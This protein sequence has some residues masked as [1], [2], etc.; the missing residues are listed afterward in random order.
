[1]GALALLVLMGWAPAGWSLGLGDIELDSALNEKLNAEIELLD[2]DGL[3]PSE[4]LVSLASAE[5]FRRIGVERFF[6]LTDLRFEVG[7]GADGGGRIE[8]T[9]TQP[10]TEPYLNFLV[11]VLWPNGRMLR[12]YTLLLDP[13][14]F[15]PAPT[16]SVSTPS[17]SPSEDVAAGQVVGFQRIGGKIEPGLDRH[18]L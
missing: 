13:P 8:V 5:D 12:E 3:Q 9:S 1:M 16:Q 4:I 15:S 2:A 18:D 10:V 6:F 11:E 14:T 7:Y 17:Q